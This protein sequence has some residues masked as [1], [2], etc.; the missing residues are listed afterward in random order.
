MSPESFELILATSASHLPHQIPI[1]GESS[2]FELI[3]AVSIVLVVSCVCSLLEAALYSL[4]ASQIEMLAD[5]GRNS[6]K[7]L[8]KL[9]ADIQRPISAILTLNTL[10]HTGGATIAGAAFVGVFPQTP[11]TYFTIAFSLAVLIF[12]EILPKTVGVVHARVLARFIARPIQWL[13]WLFTPFIWLN[14]F[15]VRLITAG[16]PDAP[17]VVPEEIEIIARMS[18]HSGAISPDQ[19][20]VIQNILKLDELRA[21]DIMTPRT[22]VHCLDR[23]LTLA[24]ARQQSGSWSHSRV[25]LYQG[26]RENIVGLVLLRDVFSALADGRDQ[27]KLFEL[28]LSIH[29]VPESARASR[30][31]KEFIQR[32]EHL[33]AVVDEYGG[34]AGIV[35]L[36]DVIEEIVG[37]EIVD[38]SDPAVDM[39]EHARQERQDLTDSAPE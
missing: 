31:F 20:R 35:T 16:A 2:Y 21:R 10:A 13:V 28:G 29:S 33:F 18:R 32:R 19:E 11:E 14:E 30:L 5:Q 3:L 8:K 37:H 6:G 15:I 12:T 9:H 24:E 23:D 25:P 22:V 27:D 1:E 26:E 39:Q 34:F 36:E 7:I 38:E 17:V 4:P